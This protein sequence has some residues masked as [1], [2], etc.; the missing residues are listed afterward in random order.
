MKVTVAPESSAAL[1]TDGTIRCLLD[2]RYPLTSRQ[3]SAA[4]AFACELA[5]ELARAVPAELGPRPVPS[6]PI[7]INR[8]TSTDSVTSYTADAQLH[9]VL[10]DRNRILACFD[11]F[12]HDCKPEV[13]RQADKSLA[14]PIHAIVIR[15]SGDGYRI[16][17]SPALDTRIAQR[18][19]TLRDVDRGPRPY[20]YDNLNPPLYIDRIRFEGSLDE[21][22]EEEEK[23]EKWEV[24]EICGD[25][26]GDDGIPEL[27]V[28]RK[29]GKKTWE[30]YE[31]VAQT[32]PEALDEYK[33]LHGQVPGD[34]V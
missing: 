3:S 12:L 10:L 18:Y 24:K 17:R 19:A 4:I 13:H 25:R 21:E 20:F 32:E 5:E 9:A 1:T 26:R 8:A 28:K 29:S 22:E 27:L 23:E 15:E 31:D 11:L 16:R 34:I 6:S 14:R 30:L 2:M 33:R 7:A